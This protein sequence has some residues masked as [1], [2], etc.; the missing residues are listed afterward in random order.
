MTPATTARPTPND[1]TMRLAVR[2][3]LSLSAYTVAMALLRERHLAYDFFLHTALWIL[4]S[5]AMVTLF[6][7]MQHVSLVLCLVN[8]IFCSG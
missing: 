4:V 2:A 5:F 3:F 1:R 8:I 7:G 6:I